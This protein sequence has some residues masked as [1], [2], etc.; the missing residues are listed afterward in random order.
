MN[1]LIVAIRVAVRHAFKC[2]CS[3]SHRALIFINLHLYPVYL[4]RTEVGVQ[5]QQD[6]CFRLGREVPVFGLNKQDLT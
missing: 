4:I 6:V 2:Q 5:K 1:V 3:Q